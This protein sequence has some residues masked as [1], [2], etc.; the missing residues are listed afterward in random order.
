MRCF[1]SGTQKKIMIKATR[2]KPAYRQKTPIT[3]VALR[4]KGSVIPST[5]AQKRQVATANPIPIS[6]WERG[7]TSAL[8]VPVSISF[9]P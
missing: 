8:L 6:R 2:L 9:C 7:N 5:A 3:P 1:V 4:I